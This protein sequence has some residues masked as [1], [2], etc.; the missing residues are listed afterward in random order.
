MSLSG[1]SRLISE[2]ARNRRVYSGPSLPGSYGQEA[3]ARHA[4]CS[5]L[6]K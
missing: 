1:D 5:A 3:S 4:G 2:A 6:V